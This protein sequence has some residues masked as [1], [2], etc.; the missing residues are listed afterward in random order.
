MKKNE[1][2]KGQKRKFNLLSIKEKLYKAKDKSINININNRLLKY[3]KIYFIVITASILISL[4]T[5]SIIVYIN[6]YKYE[7]YIKYEDKMNI[8]GFDEM[9]NNKSAKTSELV[10][11]SEA[12]KL[13][14]ATVFNTSDI[15]N[16]A[17]VNNEYNNATWV[18][19]AKDVGITKDDVNINNYY[20]NVKYINVIEY[21]ENCKLNFL[22]DEK[23]KSNEVNLEDINVYTVSEQ[24]AI[25]DMIANQII[26]IF[27]N[28][29]NGNSY[30]FKGQLN[31]I[32]VNFAEKY[33]TIAM[34]RSKVKY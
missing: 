6:N 13:A 3:N 2:V 30:I 24:A 28:N 4:I 14:L 20:N 19:Y 33:N 26:S 21:F 31:E 27:S 32:V 23:V 7:P 12:L 9:Y 34:P 1:E 8:Y 29:L 18:D 25:Q 11:I 10:T 16:F 17:I 5:N 15:S 22:K